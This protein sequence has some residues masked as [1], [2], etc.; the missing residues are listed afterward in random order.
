MYILT[1]IALPRKKVYIHILPRSPTNSLSRTLHRILTNSH[2][3][4]HSPCPHAHSR[5]PHRARLHPRGHRSTHEFN[6]AVNLSRGLGLQSQAPLVGLQS[7]SELVKLAFEYLIEVVHGQLDA[8]VGH[9][10]LAV[11]VR[12]DLLGAVARADL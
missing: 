11:V 5:I 6:D 10:A 7:R 8:M 2:E 12:A 1:T 3:S 4:R 9:A